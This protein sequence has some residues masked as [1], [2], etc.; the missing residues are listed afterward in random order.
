MLSPQELE[1]KIKA[2]IAQ[3]LS[4]EEGQVQLDSSLEDDLGADSLD[5]MELVIAFE[6]EFDIETDTE[7]IKEIR[8]VKDALAYVKQLIDAQ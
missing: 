6:E 7:S 8:T 2:I 3:Q 5:K 4:C 1:N